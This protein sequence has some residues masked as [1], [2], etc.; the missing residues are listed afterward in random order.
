MR[1]IDG[2]GAFPLLL[3]SMTRA[4]TDDNIGSGNGLVPPG[5]KPLSEPVLTKVH[6][7]IWFH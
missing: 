7:A 1:F 3:L 2:L 5:S 6:D 4:P